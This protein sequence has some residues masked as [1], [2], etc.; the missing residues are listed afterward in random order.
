[1]ATGMSDVR[2]PIGLH[3]I[4]TLPKLW[5]M[6]PMTSIG[7]GC[8]RNSIS[9][10][11]HACW[12]NRNAAHPVNAMLNYAYAILES[13]AR[14]QLVSEG[15]DP[16]FGIMHESREGSSAFVFDIMEPKRPKVAK[17]ASRQTG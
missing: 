7:R 10:S 4:S 6:F 16:T 9:R 5:V 12:G 1:M 8:K 17:H 15:Y 2:A 3:R 11:R 14:I 13:Q